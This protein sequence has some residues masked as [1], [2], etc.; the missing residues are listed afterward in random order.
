MK[1]DYRPAL[2]WMT[3]REAIRIKK[4]RGDGRVLMRLTQD[5]ILAKY[6][7]CN[8]R[9]ED[10]RVTRWIDKHIRK[11]F[12]HHNNL[13]FMLCLARQVNWPDTLSDLIYAPGVFQ[14]DGRF[15][16]KVFSRVLEKRAAEGEK[17]FTGAYIVTAGPI[18]GQSKAKHVGNVTLGRLW[19]DRHRFEHYFA[20][21][22]PDERDLQEVHSMLMEYN[23]W[24]PFLA[25]QAVVDMR[26]TNL[27]NKAYGV[28]NWA[29]AGP[30]TIRGLNRL[31]HRDTDTRITQKQALYEMTELSDFLRKATDIEYDFSDIP[32]ILCETDKYLR[33]KLGEGAPRALY[34]PGRGC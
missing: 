1:P 3:E 16:P 26:F 10:D 24:G 29:A 27:L 4:E 32:N 33:V 25:Y 17:V 8:V 20:A 6:R 15:E 21:N 34:V 19:K 14:L 18:K 13:W 9:R 7:F 30:G 23:G 28:R 22:M 2:Y 31:H 12:R 11:P 5:P